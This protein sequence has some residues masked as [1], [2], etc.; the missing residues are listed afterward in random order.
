[1]D[2][3]T[4]LLLLSD[5]CLWLLAVL[6]RAAWRRLQEQEDRDSLEGLVDSTV[7]IQDYR[8][9]F[10]MSPEQSRCCFFLSVGHMASTAAG[11][12]GSN[13]PCCTTLASVRRKVSQTWKELLDG[14][15]RGRPSGPPGLDL[16][17]SLSLLLGEWQQDCMLVILTDVEDRLMAPQPRAATGWEVDRL[18]FKAEPSLSVPVRCL[19]LPRVVQPEDSEDAA[20][21]ASSWAL[22]P[23][24]PE[25]LSPAP[26]GGSHLWETFS[27]LDGSAAAPAAGTLHSPAVSGTPRSPLPPY[28]QAPGAPAPGGA[29]PA[30][31]AG[32][33]QEAG[34]GGAKRRRGDEDAAGSPPSWLFDTLSEGGAPRPPPP[35]RRVPRRGPG[36]HADGR[37]FS[38]A[39]RVSGQ[40]L[41]HLS[42]FRVRP[43]WL[44]WA[45]RYLLGPPPAS[46][47]GPAD[48]AW[49]V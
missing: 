37:P 4:G 42:R 32:A 31:A 16:E 12:L 47:R 26:H 8:L 36:L 13:A 2:G 40:D 48:R 15:D 33:A 49:H 5:G 24:E 22:A 19:L 30:E 10:H 23:A 43:A 11:P 39:Y 41:L 34:A 38:Y 17:P 28:Q 18:R 9:Q 27:P 46:D 20:G 35:P 3:P 21:Q 1:M 29:T 7:V 45:L 25:Q 44:H 14:E 6:T